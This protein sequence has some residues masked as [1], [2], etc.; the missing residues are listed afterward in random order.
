MM[1]VNKALKIVENRLLGEA[2]IPVAVRLMKGVNKKDYEELINAILFLIDAFKGKV[3]VPKILALAFVD[4]SNHFFVPNLSYSEKELE[5][6]EDCGIQLSE[7]ANE[8][9]NDM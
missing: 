7:L 3:S 6:L 4:V 9:F 8:L 1:N 5:F 2:S